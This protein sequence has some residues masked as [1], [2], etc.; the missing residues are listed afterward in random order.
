MVSCFSSSSCVRVNAVSP[1]AHK[2]PTR[3]A[4]ASNSWPPRRH[5][6]VRQPPTR[7]L[8]QLSSGPQ[9]LPVSFTAQSWLWIEGAIEALFTNVTAHRDSHSHLSTCGSMRVGLFA[10]V[11]PLDRTIGQQLASIYYEKND[12]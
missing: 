6:V 4:R 7:L 2:A 12:T 8:R 1:G 5:R 3:W 10:T 9:I 11:D